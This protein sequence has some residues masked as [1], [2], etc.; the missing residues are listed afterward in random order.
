MVNLPQ[1]KQLRLTDCDYSKDGYY[2]V[3]ICVKD[4]YN[5][6]GE[7]VG[8]DASVRLPNMQVNQ[9]GEIVYEYWSKINEIHDCIKI[10]AFCLM[11]NHIHGIIVIDEAG[12]QGR[13]PL[14]KIMQGYK[15]VTTRMCF[16]YGYRIIWQRGY[17]E[18]IIKNENELKRIREYINTNVARWQDDRYFTS[19]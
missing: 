3:T 17:H 5:L 16:K 14:P 11:P 2:F 18:H 19:F 10:D 13:P 12:G 7:I 4:R 6:F 8:A 15:S 9:I 1:R